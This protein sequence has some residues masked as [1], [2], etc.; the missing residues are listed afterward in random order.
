MIEVK[1]PFL[2]TVEAA[3]EAHRYPSENLD[4]ANS[5]EDNCDLDLDDSDQQFPEL[6]DD[7]PLPSEITK[8][9]RINKAA[10]ELKWR[11]N[12]HRTTTV[13]AFFWKETLKADGSYNRFLIFLLM[14]SLL[15]LRCEAGDCQREQFAPCDCR[16]CF[17]EFHFDD[18]QCPLFSSESSSRSQSSQASQS[19]SSSQASHSSSSSSH[20]PHSS[21]SS[22]SHRSSQSPH[23]SQDPWHPIRDIGRLFSSWISETVIPWRLL[24]DR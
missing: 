22:S 1:A 9:L 19:S 3:P 8:T 21:Q 24:D 2:K 7:D 12:F 4:Q 6:D 10:Y 13:S 15:Q 14:Y 5:D 18:H 16:K 11:V 20:S 23:S 17:C